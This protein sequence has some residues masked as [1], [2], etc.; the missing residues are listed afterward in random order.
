MFLNKELGEKSGH[1]V[2]GSSE[3]KCSFLGRGR[4]AG[5]FACQIKKG[6]GKD[7]APLYLFY[8]VGGGYTARFGGFIFLG[9]SMT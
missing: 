3:F 9:D 5:E 2:I 8:Q 4:G 1:L 7:S 6:A